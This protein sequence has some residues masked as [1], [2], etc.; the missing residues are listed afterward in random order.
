MGVQL[1][2][3]NVLL[4]LIRSEKIEDIPQD[5]PLE[6]NINHPDEKKW[7]CMHCK[8]GKLS[9]IKKDGSAYAKCDKCGIILTKESLQKRYNPIHKN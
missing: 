8:N 5:H 4:K 3:R 6:N 2:D 9:I 1:W 7:N